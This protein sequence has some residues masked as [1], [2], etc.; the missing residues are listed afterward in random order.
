MTYQE[1][2]TAIKNACT[3]EERFIGNVL[4]AIVDGYPAWEIFQ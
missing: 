4:W 1:K 3:Y 2:Q